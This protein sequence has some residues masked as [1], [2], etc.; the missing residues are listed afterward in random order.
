MKNGGK[1]LRKMALVC[2]LAV[3]P[4]GC[5]GT[6]ALNGKVKEF[7]LKT[8]ENRWARAGLFLGLQALWITRV[9]AVADLFV[10]NS[11]EFWSGTNPVNGRVA[12]A[13][14]SISEA[15]KLG[16]RGVERAQVE[17]VSE[18]DARLHLDFQNGDHMTLDVARRD[19]TYTVRYLG[20]V[21][22]SGPI[23]TDEESAR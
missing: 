7:N 16:F 10:V 4:S 5:I 11:I 1:M 9:A 12:L 8:V 18:S 6:G 19:E 20:R 21:L 3:L 17:M 15:E 22:F 2:V 13:D 14:V 23:P